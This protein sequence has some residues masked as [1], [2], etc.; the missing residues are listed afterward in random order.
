MNKISKSETPLDA[1]GN[2]I[3]DARM[4]ERLQNRLRALKAEFENGQRRLATME[5]ETT[6]LRNTLLR[7]SG[8][9]QVLEEELGVTT[10]GSE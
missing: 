1:R 6:R 5:E 8:A 2:A 9:I 10:N 4:R 3:D 7:I